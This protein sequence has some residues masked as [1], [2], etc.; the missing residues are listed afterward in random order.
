MRMAGETR[1]KKTKEAQRQQGST[2]ITK[3][4]LASKY[5]HFAFS[6]DAFRSMPCPLG[7]YRVTSLPDS[8]VEAMRENWTTVKR[9]PAAE[10]NQKTSRRQD[11]HRDARSKGKH[12]Q[13]TQWEDEKK[14]KPPAL[15]VQARKP[16]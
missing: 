12:R 11:G 3:N 5:G 10:M 2:E 8:D 7:S 9:R 14:L 1:R 13:S 6:C 4:P 15:C 16:G